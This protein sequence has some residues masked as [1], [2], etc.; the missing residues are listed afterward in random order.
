ML[1]SATH[2]GLTQAL[3]VGWFFSNGD[4]VISPHL[5]PYFVGARYS[6]H[7]PHHA[8]AGLSFGSCGFGRALW[9][10]QLGLPVSLRNV[11][12]RPSASGCGAPGSGGKAPPLIVVGLRPLTISAHSSR[13]PLHTSPA[14]ATLAHNNSFKPNALRYTNH[15]ADTACHVV[16]SAT[17]VGLTQALG[18]H[19]R[20]AAC[21]VIYQA[22]RVLLGHRSLHR[23]YY[24]GVWDLFGGHVLPGEAPEAALARELAE[25]LGIV[26][27]VAHIALVMP[28]PNPRAHGPGEFHVFLVT[29]WTGKPKLRNAEHQALGWF[30][31]EEAVQLE[32]ADP[33]IAALLEQV[34]SGGG[35]PNNSFKPN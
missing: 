20:V 29:G 21:A 34:V 2:V 4:A 24:P 6:S 12:S 22:G 33:S 17:H 19:V 30:T 8:R 5:L 9:L 16:G 11:A 7:S 14:P 26:P 3:Y 28:E 32:L 25:E 15:M 13:Q 27:T 23:A 10:R 18:G 35:P 1:A 31:P